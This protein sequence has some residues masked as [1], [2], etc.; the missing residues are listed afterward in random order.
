MS[1]SA[2]P[3]LAAAVAERLAEIHFRNGRFIILVGL[4]LTITS[5]LFAFL[6]LPDAARLLVRGVLIAVVP[7]QALVLVLPRR[8]LWLQKLATALSLIAFAVMFVV[9]SAYAPPP[10]NA[11]VIAGSILLLGLAV[12]I[13]PL[14]ARWMMAFLGAYVLIVGAAVLLTHDGVPFVR[15]ALAL[16]LLVGLG[17]V[18]VA[19]RVG[20]LERQNV[21]LTVQNERRA[22]ALE[23]RNE[24]LI[25]LSMEDPL[26][27]LANRRALEGR[28]DNEFARA[29]DRDAARTAVMMLDIDSF[30]AFNDRWG[31]GV[32]DLCLRTVA[33]VLRATAR[34]CE[35][36]AARFGG[37]EFV[38]LLRVDDSAQAIR[39]AEAIRVAV[40]RMELAVEPESDMA[41]CTISA[42][43]ALQRFGEAADLDD[44]L[45]RAD[46][47][48]YA[49][50]HDGRNRVR[51]AEE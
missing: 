10:G 51:L 1:A 50:K 42:G 25:E 43:V 44:L 32:G 27:G 6:A 37:E 15:W 7:L 23:R 13:L 40:E 20:Q 47:A 46:A 26:T 34:D 17:G 24:R 19:L 3:E 31:H 41:H 28:F 36:V 30:K 8:L 38:L 29:L 33:Q 21:A 49:A 48:L 22:R 5:I 2:D 35:A 16:L 14:R 45:T 18:P 4:A 11:F 12:P 9:A 39:T